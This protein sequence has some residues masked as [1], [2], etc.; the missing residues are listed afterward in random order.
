[1]GVAVGFSSCVHH[2]TI[3]RFDKAGAK[4]IFSGQ[5]ADSGFSANAVVMSCVLSPSSLRQMS[6]Y[7]LLRLFFS[8]PL[9]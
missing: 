4:E 5:F 8:G 2:I 6:S 7:P 9:H 1:M 3:K